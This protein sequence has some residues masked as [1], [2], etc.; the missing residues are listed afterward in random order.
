MFILL[1]WVHD[2]RWGKYLNN[3]KEVSYL[4]FMDL[5]IVIYLSKL[6]LISW[7]KNIEALKA[8]ITETRINQM[9]IV[10]TFLF[11][12]INLFT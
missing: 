10:L 9:Y 5:Y 4:S 3:L 1:S 8:K 2:L 6:V 11:S 7:I 12:L